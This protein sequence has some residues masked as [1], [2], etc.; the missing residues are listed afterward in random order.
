MP[1]C[2]NIS[3]RPSMY[4]GPELNNPL[5]R[6]S[7]TIYAASGVSAE[8]LNLQDAFGIDVNLLLFCAWLGADLHVLLT[9]RDIQEASAAV[10]DW[11]DR[12]VRPLRSVRQAFGPN[13]RQSPLR[14]KVKAIELESEQFEQAMLYEF[15]RDR[16]PDASD[17]APA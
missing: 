6:F 16:W 14:L 17:N 8:C 12:V 15:A 4:T 11:H 5:W 1:D 13:D 10:Q 9:S 3:P 2:W 7:L